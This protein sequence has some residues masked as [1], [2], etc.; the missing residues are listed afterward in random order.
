MNI[1]G[2]CTYYT[3]KSKFVRQDIHLKQ[4]LETLLKYIFFIYT[5]ML[6]FLWMVSSCKWVFDN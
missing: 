2:T 3:C 4:A 6:A 5:Q 1:Y